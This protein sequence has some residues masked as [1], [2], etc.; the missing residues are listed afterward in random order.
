MGTKVFQEKPTIGIWIIAQQ[1]HRL[2]LNLK[3][4]YSCFPLYL[5]VFLSCYFI[6]YPLFTHLLITKGNIL[7]LKIFK[8]IGLTLDEETCLAC[9]WD[10]CCSNSSSFFLLALK[11]IQTQVQISISENQTAIKGLN[12]FLVPTKS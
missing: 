7:S 4:L 5:H 11:S 3:S 8:S 2:Q 10:H 12:I 1:L 6:Q 9:Q